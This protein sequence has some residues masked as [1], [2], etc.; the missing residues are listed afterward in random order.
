MIQ[1][2]PDRFPSVRPD[3][4]LRRQKVRR[5]FARNRREDADIREFRGELVGVGKGVL[6][7]INTEISADRVVARTR[8]R[9][10]KQCFMNL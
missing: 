8:E 4:P 7:V 3:G 9:C 5:L 10:I 2:L 6:G 1:P